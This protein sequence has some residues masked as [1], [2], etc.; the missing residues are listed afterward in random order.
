MTLTRNI[1][2]A[3]D[4]HLIRMYRWM[5]GNS[6][7]SNVLLRLVVRELIGRKLL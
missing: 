5:R 7:S 6:T 3:Q 4:E 2:L 1:A